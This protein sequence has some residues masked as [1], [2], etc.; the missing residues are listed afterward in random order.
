[1]R[2]IFALALMVIPRALGAQESFWPIP[3]EAQG[4]QAGTDSY[5]TLLAE[6]E[7]CESSSDTDLDCLILVDRAAVIAD[8][9]GRPEESLRFRFRA[10]EI[11]YLLAPDSRHYVWQANT[12]R[13]LARALILRGRQPDAIPLLENAVRVRKLIASRSAEPVITDA[14]FMAG[15]LLELASASE[16]SGRLGKVE[17]HLLEAYDLLQLIG[18]DSSRLA[19]EIQVAIGKFFLATGRSGA[20]HSY[21]Q[22][23]LA[24]YVDREMPD[25]KDTAHIRE[26][27]G[28][29]GMLDGDYA[30]AEALYNKAFSIAHGN[31][32][33]ARSER[34][35]AMAMQGWLSLKLGE[36]QLALGDAF[37]A[38]HNFNKGL[39][40]A[41]EN[42]PD[43][44]CLLTAL[45][46]RLAAASAKLGMVENQRRHLELGWARS[47]N[48]GD[49]GDSEKIRADAALA[50]AL[51]REGEDYDRARSLFLGAMTGIETRLDRAT[52]FDAAAPKDLDSYRDIFQGLV[53]TSWQLSQ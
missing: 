35:A 43:N 18:E 19:I 20:A 9:T 52:E 40:L 48:L 8:Q 21:L 30:K 32:P 50:I 53:Q 38:R 39:G 45:H 2:L 44:H 1:M 17:D 5:L 3:A 51:Q 15:T 25:H 11:A 14:I 34:M 28:D 16:Y 26:L 10:A 27:L 33:R 22:N 23:A 41:S 24:W 46:L 42:T 37:G 12:S 7:R 29:L 36:A 47:R 13:S 31:L 49:I 6:L 4:L